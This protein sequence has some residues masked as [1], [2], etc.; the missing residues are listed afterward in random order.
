MD[1]RGHPVAQG[2]IHKAVSADPGLS[3]KVRR[4]DQQLEMTATCSRSRMPMV[5]S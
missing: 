5:R 4:D 3:L 1:S 2:I